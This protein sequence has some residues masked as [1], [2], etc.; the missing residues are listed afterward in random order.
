M[1][2]VPY[3][4]TVWDYVE[5]L[6]IP[7]TFFLGI[8]GYP[9]LTAKKGCGDYWDQI[10]RHYLSTSID[11]AEE[12][13]SKDR[14]I[15]TPLRTEFKGPRELQWGWPVALGIYTREVGVRTVGD[16]ATV[17][18][19]AFITADDDPVEFTVA[20]GY[21]NVNELL[22]YYPG[23]TKYTL[24]PTSVVISGGT[25]T[26]QIPRAR[27]LLPIYYQNYDDVNER[28][29]YTT[30]AHFLQ[31][32]DV[33]REYVDTTTGSNL[34]WH[35]QYPQSYDCVSVDAAC[36]PSTSC[37][38]TLQLACAYVRDQRQGVVMYE[39]ATYNGGW[40]KSVRAVKRDPD[41]IQTQYS[42]G[43][44]QRYEEI[45]SQLT[46]AV[47]AIAHNNFPR[48]PC[49]KCALQQ[50]YYR[51]DVEPLEPAANMGMGPSTWGIYEAVQ[52]IEDFIAD[53]HGWAGGLF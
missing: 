40:V 30:D 13:M 15:G 36:N 52:I 49:F 44:Y 19:S 32:V 6:Q 34:V 45:E 9:G 27:L 43:W 48:D 18:I 47:I 28:P 50:E 14:W 5:F 29:V 7:E 8:R 37:G 1:W 38:E 12:R 46:R 35:R 41:Y 4:H 23:Q 22:L 31:S 20:V 39:P 11:K 51:R 2:G 53:Q 10:D 21:T 16:A 26:V 3:T 42:Q 25:A 17:D 33:R 24:R